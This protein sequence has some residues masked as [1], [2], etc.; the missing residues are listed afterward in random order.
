VDAKQIPQ[1]YPL[2]ANH[3]ITSLGDSVSECDFLKVGDFYHEYPGGQTC[4]NKPNI[5]LSAT[6]HL[7]SAQKAAPIAD[8]EKLAPYYAPVKGAPI[9]REAFAALY[10]R[11]LPE[12]VNP[13]KGNYTIN[14]PLGDM[15]GSFI[16]RQLLKMMNSQVKKMFKSTDGEENPLLGM[17]ENMLKEMPLRSMLM[18]SNGALKRATLESLLLMI[19]GSNFKG[20][21]ALLKSLTVKK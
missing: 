16:G 19:N 15:S 12:N 13:Q 9:N 20:F 1:A 10:G 11:A 14:T 3:T 21:L 17:V 2:N 8:R 4:Q 5:R 6:L 7:D 18:M